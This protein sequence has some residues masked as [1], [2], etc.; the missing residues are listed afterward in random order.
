MATPPGAPG[1]QQ[2]LVTS[3]AD[4]TRQ[5]ALWVEDAVN[6]DR[7]CPSQL[8]LLTDANV[9]RLI[10]AE[11][12]RR[13][14]KELLASRTV[15]KRPARAAVRDAPG[16]DL[17]PDPRHARTAAELVA[18]LRDFHQWAGEPSFRAMADQCG[19]RVSASTLHRA[20]ASSALPSF[21]TVLAV[22]IGC[23]GGE[24]DQ[25]RFASAWRMVRSARRPAVGS[26]PA[27]L[28]AV[29]AART[30]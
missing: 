25:R 18:A 8:A 23:G 7:P 5:A 13:V 6:V 12:E 28:R 3:G 30:G 1:R 11:A 27:A 17:R 22:V 26:P 29:P 14:V 21:D 4:D 2:R 9:S 19:Q 24:E 15:S 16:T 20:L 10:R